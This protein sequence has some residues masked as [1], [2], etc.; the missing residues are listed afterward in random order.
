MQLMCDN[1]SVLGSRHGF[2]MDPLRKNCRLI[3]FDKFDELPVFHIQAGAEIEGRRLNFPL[4]PEGEPFRFVDQRMTPCTMALIGI[5]SQGM[6]KVKLEFITPFKPR[7]AA[8]STVPVLGIRLIAEKMKGGF[9]WDKVTGTPTKATLF[10]EIKGNP[11]ALKNPTKTG[12][13]IEF[14]SKGLPQRDRLVAPGA[15]FENGRFV[16]QVDLAGDESAR[17]MEIFWCTHSQATLSVEGQRQ[18]FKYGSR[19][20]DLNVVSDWAVKHGRDLL[21]NARKVQSIVAT[22]NCSPAVNHLLCQTLHT[23]LANTWWVAQ[24]DRDW[25][26]VWEGSCHFHSTVDVE[27][28]QAPFYLCLWPELLKFELDQ[29]P[30]FSK[31]GEICAGEPGRGTLFLSHDVGAEITA[32]GQVYPH[33]MEVEETRNYIILSFAYWRRTGDDTLIRKHAD[34]LRKY[35]AFLAACDTTGDGVPDLGCANTVDD[36]SPAIQFGK[37]Q[38]YLAVKCLAAYVTGAALLEHLGDKASAKPYLERAGLIRRAVNETAWI[39]DHFAALLVKSGKLKDPWTGE[40]KEWNE[41]PGWDAPHIYTSNTLGLLDMVG[42]DLGLDPA[43]IK[44]DLETATRRCLRE[45]GCIHTDFQNAAL[46]QDGTPGLAGAASNPG[47]IS[48][49]MVRDMAAFYRGVDLRNLAERYWDFQVLTNTQEP[50]LFFETF[51]GN[52]LCFYPRGVAIWGYFEALSGRVI[53]KV[54]G[55]NEIW[56]LIAGCEVPDLFTAKW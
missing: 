45:Y 40:V 33:E 56:P 2:I 1:L 42:L 27:F 36:A 38:V 46:N 22:N 53:D 15:G 44:M 13:D 29:W 18:P 9:R 10:F 21:D 51:N 41:I 34:A 8:F 39:K 14:A 16:K 26:S 24:Q 19:F 48:M 49:N 3:R 31:P 52:N 55:R 37:K 5:D 43:K 47:W 54:A 32:N 7:D 30:G 20:A 23:W 11:L 35:L 17:T 25:F 4:G 6:V 12:V 50:K 28:T